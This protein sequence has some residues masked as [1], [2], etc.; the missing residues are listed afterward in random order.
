M[1]PLVEKALDELARTDSYAAVAWLERAGEPREVAAAFADLVK[2]CYW[3][4]RDLRLATAFGRA[5]AQF[6]LGR[7]AALAGS[8]AIG[9]AEL[10]NRARAICYNVASFCWPGWDEPG[11]PIG[12]SDQ[13]AGFD[14]ARAHV[15]LVEE[16]NLGEV[17]RARGRWILAAHLLAFHRPEEAKRLF[18]ES[19]AAAN[20]GGAKADETLARAFS[21]LV[22]VLSGGD[23]QAPLRLERL[24]RALLAHDGGSELVA[25]LQTARRV[26]GRATEP[27]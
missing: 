13:W 7:S 18:E 19:A 23:E 9:A 20:K 10:A 26:F 11:I 4:R 21:A 15:R 2:L 5:G 3:E 22:D 14:A 6:C 1:T 17:A 24:E 25:Q 27:A 12:P 16:L 8:D